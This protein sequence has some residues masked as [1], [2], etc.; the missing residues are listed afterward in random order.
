LIGLA[1]AMGHIRVK[2]VDCW[3]QFKSNNFLFT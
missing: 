2:L 3:P 1:Q